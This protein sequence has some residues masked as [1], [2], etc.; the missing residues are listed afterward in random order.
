[1]K[2]SLLSVNWG[3]DVADQS[4]RFTIG[5][6][7]NNIPAVALN[8]FVVPYMSITATGTIQEMLFNFKGNPKGIGGTFNMKHKDL[9]VSILDKKS[10]EKKGV[11]SAVANIFIK[12]DS[13]KFPEFV[14][15]EDVERDPTKSFFNLFWKG[16]EDGLKKTLIGIDIGKTKKTVEDAKATVKDVRS[17]VKDVK[18]NISKAIS[19]PEKE[20]EKK[21]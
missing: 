20:N 16:I 8:A 13:G 9:K 11:L 5:G 7:L 19:N 18:N 2:T 4:D 17:S 10:K 21:P 1:M 3:F 14:V 15:V 12:T 6:K